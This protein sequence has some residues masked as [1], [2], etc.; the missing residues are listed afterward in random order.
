MF[1]GCPKNQVDSE[2][3]LGSLTEAGYSLTTDQRSADLVVIT[4]CAFL[5]SAVRESEA[6]IREALK[7]KQESPSKKVVVA[8]C[9]VE[10]YGKSLKRK[11]PAVDLWVPL[12]DMPRIPRLLAS[13]LS[14]LASASPHSA[15]CNLESRICNRPSRLSPLV[16]RSSARVHRSSFIVHR[17]VPPRISPRVLSTPPHFAYLKIADGCDN[18]CSYCM[19]PDI[20]G[21]FR[22]R[23]MRDI[24]DEARSLANAGVKE[25][26]LVAQDTTLYGTDF[27]GPETRLHH[28]DTKAQ[29]RIR[30]GSSVSASCSSCLSGSIPVLGGFHGEPQLARLLA[31]LG[32]VKG[33]RW[34]RLMYTHPAHLTEDVI[35]QFATNPKL[36]RYIDLPIQHVA[37][38]LLAKMNRK[39]TRSD[40]ELLLESLR[41][42]PDMHIRTTIIVGLP[43]ETAQDFAELLAFVRAARF[44]RLSC[45]AYSPEPG[46][47]AARM[48]GQVSPTVKRERVRRLMLAQ[49]AISRAGLKKL[50][51]RKLTVLVDSPDIART[52]W[53]APEIDGVVKLSGR[54][55]ASGRFVQ[56]LVTGSSTHDLAARPL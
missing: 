50:V 21:P 40:I 55:V 11:F 2:H 19:I 12:A 10:R 25:L 31:E 20:R 43:G 8:G 39:Y 27:R 42:I 15:I 3:V 34:L 52:E 37:D 46:T 51:G 32:K 17:S 14:R 23:P 18:R 28:K 38:H 6:A 5:Q 29:S 7:H 16:S 35:D 22:S 9:L 41:A 26:I 30:R 47:R 56:A 44:D 24:I 45:Y 33:I 1:L 53:D 48:P 54:K 13:R 49:A 36:C 4:T